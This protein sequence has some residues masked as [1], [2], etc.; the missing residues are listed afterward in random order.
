[1]DA[2]DIR[3]LLAGY[4]AVFQHPVLAPYPAE[5]PQTAG[6]LKRIF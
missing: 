3:F 4:P 6:Y 5:E 2:P 1:M